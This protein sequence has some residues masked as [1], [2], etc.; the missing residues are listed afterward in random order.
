[1]SSAGP[2]VVALAARNLWRNRRRTLIALAALVLGA[3]MIVLLNGFR[4]GVV[5]LMTEGMVKAQVGAFQIHRKGYMEAIEGAPLKFQIEDTAAM[6]ARILAIPGVEA[7]APRVSFAGIAAAGTRSSL[8]FVLAADPHIELEVF[9]L[10]VR[11]IAGRN[12]TQV[13]YEN[14]ALLGGQLMANLGLKPGGTFTLTAQTPEGQTNAVD[15]EVHGWVPQADP[16][17]SKRLAAM[18]LSYAQKLLRMEGRITEYAVQVR[19][20]RRIDEVAQAARQALGD[21]YEVHTWLEIQ[22]MY[23]DII[24]RQNFVLS[25]V[26]IVLFAIVFTGIVNVMAMSV[27]ERVREIGTMMA[28]GMHR[29]RILALFLAEGALLGL[30]G[31]ALGAGL[32][33]A[34]VALMGWRGVPFKAP[35]ATGTMPLFPNVSLGFVGLVVLVALVGAVAA[36]LVPAW[37][38]ARISPADAL[39]AV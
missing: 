1:M 19:D 26:S 27:Y 31:A 12:L 29:L 35:G 7:L 18:R 17:N 14:A 37:R 23:R 5:D 20:L 10:A 30:W 2:L 6:R 36:A 28:L 38:A 8:A 25:A 24:T 22:P 3:F 32:G 39:R 11:F 34:A 33:W 21:D 9:P 13:P 16:F 4:N 15:L